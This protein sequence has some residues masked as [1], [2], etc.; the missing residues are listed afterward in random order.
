MSYPYQFTWL[1]IGIFIQVIDR[2]GDRDD[3][4]D[5][6]HCLIVQAL[7]IMFLHKKVPIGIAIGPCYVVTTVYL[8]GLLS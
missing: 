5:D 1:S 3:D 4:W 8:V 2:D 7:I 6:L